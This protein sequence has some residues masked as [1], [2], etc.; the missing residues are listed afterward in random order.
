[1]TYSS[2][3]SDEEVQTNKTDDPQ[4]AKEAGASDAVA[5]LQQELQQRD[6]MISLKSEE[7]RRLSLQN[8]DYENQVRACTGMHC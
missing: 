7:I 4:P 6:E 3:L 8:Q 5:E 1:M 2:G